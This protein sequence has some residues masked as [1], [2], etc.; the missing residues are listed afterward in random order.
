M[1]YVIEFWNP[2]TGCWQRW[3]MEPVSFETASNMVFDRCF[4]DTTFT[5]RA[6]R[7]RSTN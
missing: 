4:Y 2:W 1:K 3:N 5:R 6:R 7:A